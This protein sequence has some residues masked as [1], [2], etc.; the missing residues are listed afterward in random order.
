MLLGTFVKI[1]AISSYAL[2][3]DWKRGELGSNWDI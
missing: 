3:L 2:T 1:Y